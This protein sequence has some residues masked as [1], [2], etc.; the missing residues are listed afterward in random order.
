MKQKPEKTSE[1]RWFF[2]VLIGIGV[3]VALSAGLDNLLV[4]LPVGVSVGFIFAAGIYL[5]DKRQKDKK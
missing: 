4:G 2:G 3:A 1:N 5:Q